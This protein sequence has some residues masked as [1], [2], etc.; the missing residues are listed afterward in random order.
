[1]TT[2]TKH[3]TGKIECIGNSDNSY[4]IFG[5]KENSNGQAEFIAK[6]DENDV[7][8]NLANANRIVK[9]WNSFDELVGLVYAYKCVIGN[10][11]YAIDHDEAKLLYEKADSLL[12]SLK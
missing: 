1:M 7:Y 8:K 6:V 9:A 2:E 11:G 4:S 12:N 3:T 10:T 5:D